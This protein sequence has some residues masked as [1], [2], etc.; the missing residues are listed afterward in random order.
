MIRF[1]NISTRE[2]TTLAGTAGVSGITDGSSV[3]ARF[4]SPADISMDGAGSFVVI[5]R[6]NPQFT[7]A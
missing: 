3:E 6:T 4:N 7:C 2:V 1:V 5:V